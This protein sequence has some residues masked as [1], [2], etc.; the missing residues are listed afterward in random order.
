MI[1]I[2]NSFL[3]GGDMGGIVLVTGG[4]RGI[5]AAISLTFR[6]AG[7]KVAANYAHNEDA[8]KKFNAE[9]GIS[10]FKWDVASFDGCAAGVLEVEKT[11]GDSVDVLVNNAGIT[12]D[13]ML[14]KMTFDQWQQVISTNLTSCFNMCRATVEKMR[15]KNFGRIIN[16]SSVNAQIGQMGQTNYSGAKAGVLGFTKALA[17]ENAAKGITVNAVA[18]GYIDTDM[19]A[20]VSEKALQIIIAK[21]PVGRLG[22][23]EEVASVVLFLADKKAG[24]ITGETISVNGGLGME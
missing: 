14:H 2:P 13:A 12:R 17:R 9:T 15:A 1:L 11:L 16:I 7:Y 19:V 5:G 24:F 6:D 22:T 23:P 4:T 8:A 21:V 3:S 18:P 20:A 10:V